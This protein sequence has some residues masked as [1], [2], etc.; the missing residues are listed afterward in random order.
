MAVIFN[1]LLDQSGL[2][3]A[4][5]SDINGDGLADLIVG[6][7]SSDPAAGSQA[8][9]S[10]V[11]FGSTAGTLSQ[12]AV[13]QLGGGG[14]DTLTGSVVSE[15]LV[16]GA[17]NDTLIGN[18]GADVLYG[19][20]GDDRIE[21]NADNIA[22]LG[23]GVTDGNYARVDGGGGIDTLAV[24]GA[25]V[26]LNLAAIANQGGASPSSASRIE[27]IERIDITGSVDNSLTV[28][29][30]DVQDMQG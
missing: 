29:L 8:G 28:G 23:A 17:G 5:A 12:T 3:V 30:L 20:A 19:G 4:S 22:K 18:G 15:T 21:V 1:T 26:S 13:D 14:N 6:A 2:G 24:S 7:R 11:I 9:R 25:G 10:Y 16:A 27:S